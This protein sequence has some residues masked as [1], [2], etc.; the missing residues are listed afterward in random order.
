MKLFESPI[1]D[2][3]ITELI[4]YIY[5][6]KTGKKTPWVLDGWGAEKERNKIIDDFLNYLDK[7]WEL[8]TYAYGGKTKRPQK[9]IEADEKLYKKIQNYFYYGKS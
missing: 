8:S 1:K 7:E 4:R 6:K 3:I 2:I 9:A 5:N